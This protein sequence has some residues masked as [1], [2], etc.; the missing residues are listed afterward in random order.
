MSEA[1][2]RYKRTWRYS[3]YISNYVNS[4][5]IHELEKAITGLQAEL[6][7]AKESLEKE[8]NND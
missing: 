4:G 7:S 1:M 5:K 8:E 3:F 6:E 2:R